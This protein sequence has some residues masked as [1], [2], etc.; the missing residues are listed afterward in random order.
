M[1][2]LLCDTPDR[3][4]TPSVEL[5][6]LLQHVEKVAFSS[7]GALCRFVFCDLPRREKYAANASFTH[8]GWLV[9]WA[10]TMH[11]GKPFVVVVSERRREST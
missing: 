7:D 11:G 4:R 10:G 6:G 2:Q 5:H 9:Y 3:P 8:R 1:N